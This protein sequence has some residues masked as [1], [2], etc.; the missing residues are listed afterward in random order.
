MTSVGVELLEYLADFG[1]GSGDD[2][3]GA[4]GEVLTRMLEE[5]LTDFTA[6]VAEVTYAETSTLESTLGLHSIMNSFA[7][8]Y[9]LM[10][11]A[12]S[13]SDRGTRILEKTGVFQVR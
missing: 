7:K 9:F 1:G 12:L 6:C 8:D 10:V 4:T 13:Y 5:F 3:A 11:G 2:G